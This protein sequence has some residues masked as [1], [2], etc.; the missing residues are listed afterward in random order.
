MEWAQVCGGEQPEGIE[1]MARIVERVTRSVPMVTAVAVLATTIGAGSVGKSATVTA[2]GTATPATVTRS[3][4][5][6]A[7]AD[8]VL[9]VMALGD[10]ISRGHGDPYWNGYRA[11]LRARLTAVGLR[12]NFVG[13]WLDG[14]GDN[15]HA[16]TSGARID[17]IG[18]QVPQL[19]RNY[20]PDVVL[21]MAG[22]NDVGQHYDLVG[23]GDRMTALI[24]RIRQFRP[25]AR[26]FVATIPAWTNP[27]RKPEVDL[28]NAS[29]QQAVSGLA[30]PQVTLVPNHIVGRDAAKDLSD[31][32]HPTRC[33]FAKLAY[34]WFL[35]M[36]E[37][38]VNPKPGSWSRGYWPWGTGRGACNP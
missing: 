2:A 37:S 12:P 22:T 20:R 7:G 15:N 3:L 36:N 17:Q 4:S 26:V 28:M 21:L 6:L 14:A 13:P 31:G 8:G 32:V 30:D 19:M 9:D 24:Q 27:E 25:T 33:G 10:S 18:S 5:P 23:A 35:Y 1:I 34:V 16:G 29:I 38:T 11:D